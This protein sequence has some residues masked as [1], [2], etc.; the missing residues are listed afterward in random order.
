MT[1]DQEVRAYRLAR[2]RAELDRQDIGAALLFD[3]INIRYATGSRNMQVWTMHAPCRYAFVPASG[4]VVLF[5]V[6]AARH[7]AAGLETID[8]VRPAMAWDHF[9]SGDRAA[10]HAG[11]LAAEVA[12]LLHETCGA[13]ARL[14]LDR[15]DLL[16]LRALE[17]RGVQLVDAKP[18]LDLARAIKSPKEIGLIRQ[19]L[20]SC[21]AAVES[22]R[23][24]VRPGVREC[25]LLALLNQENIARGGEYQETRLMT[26]GPRTN[27]WFQE[28]SDRVLA[29]GDL[30]AFDTDLI[31]RQG[32]FTDLS[33]TW[34]VGDGKPNDGQRRL[35]EAAFR[36]LQHNIELLRPGLG[37]REMTEKAWPLPE[38]FVEH[39][40]AD[41][42]H[43]VGLGVEWPMIYPIQDAA[44]FQ[45][46]GQFEAGMAVCC[47][48]YIGAVGGGE[49]VKLEQPLLITE[50]GVEALS[51]T[52]FETAFL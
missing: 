21:D 42:A 6:G 43:G 26:S 1:H 44:K 34:L 12:E 7:L 46:D 14:A 37:F 50:T 25:D 10:E 33:R 17:Q 40:Y 22:L 5:E 32:I 41:I 23:Q 2:T 24:A 13:E 38:A 47:E 15:A 39:R 36:Q 45:F 48:S 19:A 30:L 11:L 3:P 51:A 18:V 28:T 8:E 31:G 4:P 9:G 35:Y 16:P 20:T 52:P 29:S 49:G 27:P